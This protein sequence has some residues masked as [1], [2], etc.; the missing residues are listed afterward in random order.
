MERS[1]LNMNPAPLFWIT[2]HYNEKNYMKK[3]YTYT[4]TNRY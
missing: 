4:S 2:T 1:R 3:I